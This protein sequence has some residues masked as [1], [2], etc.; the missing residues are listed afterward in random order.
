MCLWHKTHYSTKTKQSFTG[1]QVFE[2]SILNL[3]PEYLK[4]SSFQSTEAQE[5]GQKAQRSDYIK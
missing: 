4:P 1:E 3:F 2:V 5:T